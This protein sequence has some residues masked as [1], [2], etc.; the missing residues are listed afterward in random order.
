MQQEQQAVQQQ[1]TAC[2]QPGQNAVFIHTLLPTL[3]TQLLLNQHAA[4]YLSC[5]YYEA[6]SEL[7]IDYPPLFAWFEYAMAQ[8][9]RYFDPKMLSVSNLEY[10]STATVLFLRLSVS[11]TGLV[12]VAAMLHATRRSK[13][14]P[15][16][17][18]AFFLA[19]CNAG[20]IMVDNIHFQYNGILLGKFVTAGCSRLGQVAETSTS[21]SSSST[22]NSSSVEFA[23]VAAAGPCQS[24]RRQQQQQRQVCRGCSSR[25]STDVTADT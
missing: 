25:I 6:T 24:H 8:A 4:L 18:T 21:S 13:N 12:S 22:S 3:Q 23:P 1:Q 2:N 9:A 5:R 14:S 17:L 20:L 11:I 19:V 7:T 15:A 16:G 10:E